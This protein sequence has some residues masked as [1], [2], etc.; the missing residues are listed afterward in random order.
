MVNKVI[1]VGNLGQD[2]ELRTT[3]GGTPVVNLRLATSERRKDNASGEWVEHTEWHTVIAFGKTAENVHQYCQKGKQLYIEGK[4]QTRKWQDREGHDRWSTEI[5][6]ETVRFL[7]GGRSEEA[8]APAP[9][10]AP[11]QSRSGGRPA[12]AP[13]RS[14]GTTRGQSRGPA[15]MPD[16]DIPF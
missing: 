12:P 7:G 14:Q 9:A 4:L 8:P 1:L 5:I 15:P 13:A 16:E 10:P 6:A 3:G 2:P 11:Q